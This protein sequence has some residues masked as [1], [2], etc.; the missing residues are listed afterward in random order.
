[1]VLSAA[2]IRIGQYRIATDGIKRYRLGAKMAGRG[3]R[4][5]SPDKFG[6]LYRPLQDLHPAYRTADHG[7]KL[8]YTEPVQQ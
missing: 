7:Q 4:H 1:M 2:E 6:I 3:N 8:P 5:R